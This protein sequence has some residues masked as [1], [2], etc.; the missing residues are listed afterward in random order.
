MTRKIRLTWL[1]RAMA[2]PLAVGVVF[3]LCGLKLNIRPLMITGIVVFVVGT[4][5]GV[6][7][8]IISRHPPIKLVKRWKAYIAL[9]EDP[10]TDYAAELDMIDGNYRAD[11]SK[12]KNIFD[13]PVINDVQS[14]CDFSALQNG[15][16]Y[17]GYLMR[18]NEKLFLPSE[19]IDEAFPAMLLYS[20][21]EYYKVN[22]QELIK[23]VDALYADKDNNFLR[24]ETL[25]HFN[26]L[27]DKGLTDGREVFVTDVLA[28]RAHLPMG[29]LGNLRIIPIIADPEKSKS[30]FVVDCKYWTNRFI[31][32]YITAGVDEPNTLPKDSD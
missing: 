2:I 22:P 5:C 18:A 23:I 28:C 32:A 7:I 10:I 26:E 15:K 14:F 1:F 19:N 4:A 11:K 3:L 21:D 31:H 25:Y 6:A 12:D 20:R 9:K 17:Y 24:Y 29:M 30:C 27:L 13:K 8:K 16:L